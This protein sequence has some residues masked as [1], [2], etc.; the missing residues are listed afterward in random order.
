MQQPVVRERALKNAEKSAASG[1]GDGN[2][3]LISSAMFLLALTM[4]LPWLALSPIAGTEGHRI[5]PAH[6]MVQSGWWSVPTLFGRP[7]LAKPPLH[8]WL[9]AW[10]ETIFGRANVFVWRLPSAITGAALCAVACWFGQRWFGRIAGLISGFSSVGLITIWGQAH[11]ADIDATNTLAAAITAFCGIELLVVRWP[12]GVV[13]LPFI[14]LR[15]ADAQEGAEPAPS[16]GI[17]GEGGGEGDF[18]RQRSPQSQITLTPT[19]SRGTGRGG[20][21]G[22]G[23]SHATRNSRDAHHD[24]TALRAWILTAGAALAATFL[25]KGPGALPIIVGV[26]LWGLIAQRRSERLSLAASP[27]FWLP[28][29]MMIVVFALWVAAAVHGLHHRGLTV[30]WAGVREG[31]QRL[32]GHSLL[33]FGKSLIVLSPQL[34]LF[35][36]PVSL[37]LPFYFHPDVEEELSGVSGRIAKALVYAVLLSWAVCLVTAM[38]NPRYGYPTLIPLC[39]LAGAVAVAAASSKRGTELLKIAAG[40]S[41]VLFLVGSVILTIMGWKTLW[42][43]PLLVGTAMAQLIVF[44]W[45]LRRLQDEWRGAWGLAMLAVLTIIPFSVHEQLSRTA[46]SGISSAP[47][48]RRMFGENGV[49]AVAGAVDNRPEAFYYSGVRPDYYKSPFLPSYVKPG[50]WVM[51][52]QDEHKRWAN[53][54]GVKLEDDQ[55][56]CKWGPTTYNMAW[57]AAR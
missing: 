10:S 3:A 25:T 48:F 39:P 37:A 34:F 13:R 26:W 38:D 56:L 28:W 40:S 8:Y 55:F 17:P 33:S 42:A 15:A 53:T 9:I 43:K 54:P 2:G 32:H 5:L 45:T 21:A 47:L 50:T 22:L 31:T 18:E 41:A 44:G 14:P 7:Y 51:L 36:L 30:D 11:V 29:L 16:P 23:N 24:A 12:P 19:L 57:Y 27:R 35:S 1:S 4:H 20:K 46:T 52:D 6:A 49:V